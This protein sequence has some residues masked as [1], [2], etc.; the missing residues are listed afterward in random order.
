MQKKVIRIISN[1]NFNAHTG[2]LFAKLKIMPYHTIITQS[3]LH[4]MHSAHYKCSPSLFHNI[5][6]TNAERNPE[7]NL[8]N[9]DDYYIPRANLSFFQRCPLYCTP[10]PRYG[11]KVVLLNSIEIPQLLKSV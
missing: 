4:L 6:S 7:L 9:A 3:S 5:W 1:A 11:I 10:F 8:R 2:P